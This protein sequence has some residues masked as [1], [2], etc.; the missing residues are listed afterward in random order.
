MGKKLTGLLVPT[1]MVS[2]AYGMFLRPILS[3]ETLR[4]ETVVVPQG[5]SITFDMDLTSTSKRVV[6]LDYEVLEGGPIGVT[7]ATMESTRGDLSRMRMVPGFSSPS[8]MSGSADALVP[9][10]RWSIV[11]GPVP[12]VGA[13]VKIKTRLHRPRWFQRVSAAAE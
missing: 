13:K 9:A 11:M 3:V 5:R 2:V 8:T 12:G 4:D 7:L 10:G 1:L 6:T